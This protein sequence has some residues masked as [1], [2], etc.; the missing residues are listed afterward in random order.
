MWGATGVLFVDSVS[1]DIS[2]HA[3]RVGSDR[4]LPEESL[5]SA[6]FNS[7]SPCGERQL[8]CDVSTFAIHFNSRSPCG[9]RLSTRVVMRNDCDFNSRS[10]CGERREAYTSSSLSWIF[11]LTL[12]VWGATTLRRP[13]LTCVWDFNSRSPCGERPEYMTAKSDTTKNFNSRSPCGERRCVEP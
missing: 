1:R 11:Q 4:R 6:N 9:E 7:R 2:T 3:P 5:I 13:P 8:L 12:P 10:P